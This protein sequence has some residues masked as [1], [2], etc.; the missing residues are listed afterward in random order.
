M[1]LAKRLKQLR[2]DK[3][4]S[5]AELGAL[6]GLSKQSISAY[7][8]EVASPSQETLQSFAGFFE[9]SVDY[10]L[11]RT[12]SPKA[13]LSDPTPIDVGRMIRDNQLSFDGI[14]L[15]NDDKEDVIDFIK[16]ALRLKRKNKEGEV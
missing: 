3:G 13:V 10:L 4:M 11:G 1:G 15:D 14:A 8:N 6:F 9:V 5:Q 12:N 2:I 7:E 16:I